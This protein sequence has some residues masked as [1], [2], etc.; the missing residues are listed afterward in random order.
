LPPSLEISHLPPYACNGL[1]YTETSLFSL[2]LGYH[3]PAGMSTAKAANFAS[4][5]GE[6]PAKAVDHHS[7][8]V[9]PPAVAAIA[10]S[11]AGN[12]TAK[13]GMSQAAHGKFASTAVNHTP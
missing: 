8:A 13:A 4:T 5:A 3:T 9:K 11:R 7:L 12:L 2:A 6:C 10:A 1:F